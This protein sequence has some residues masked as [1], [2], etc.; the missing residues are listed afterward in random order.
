L[1][2]G[3]KQTVVYY[4]LTKT[5]LKCL[6]QRFGYLLVNRIYNILQ[7]TKYNIKF[8]ILKYLSNFCY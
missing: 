4:N 1:F 8:E 7:N 6:Y 5:E 3:K 2:Y